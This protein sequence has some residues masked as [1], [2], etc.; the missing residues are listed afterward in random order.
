MSGTNATAPTPSPS[1]S[2]STGLPAH[3]PAGLSPSKKAAPGTSIRSPSSVRKAPRSFASLNQS[4]VPRTRVAVTLAKAIDD[5]SAFQVVGREL[6]PHAVAE[7]QPDAI[8]LHPSTQV[9]EGLVA[10]V[11]LNPEHA[12]AKGLHDLPLELD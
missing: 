4:I 1:C 12:A 2:N 11:E 5:P 10:V 6:D 7:H 9:A 3:R 8:P